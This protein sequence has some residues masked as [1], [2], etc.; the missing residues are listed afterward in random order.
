MGNVG[1]MGAGVAVGA[2]GVGG[3][4]CSHAMKE[5][6]EMHK[7]IMAGE[8]EAEIMAA[9]PTAPPLDTGEL[10]RLIACEAR[11]SA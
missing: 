11:G 5:A 6:R 2:V 10:M 4:D 8:T 1:T 3:G 7:V 9:V